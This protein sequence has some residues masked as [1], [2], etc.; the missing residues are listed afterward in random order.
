MAGRLI[1]ARRVDAIV[2]DQRFAPSAIAARARRKWWTA[3]AACPPYALQSHFLHTWAKPRSVMLHAGAP[4]Q[5]PRIVSND[6]RSP[7]AVSARIALPGKRPPLGTILDYDNSTPPLG[8]HSGAPMKAGYGRRCISKMG[9]RHETHHGHHQAFQ[10]R[11][12]AGGADAAGRAGSH[13]HRG[14]GFRPPKGP[15]RDLPRRR[16]PRELSA[17]GEDRGRGAPTTWSTRSSRRSPRPPTPARSATAR[18]SS[19]TSSVRCASAP[20]RPTARRI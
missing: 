5:L 10:A 18:S 16:V 3:Q 17:Q 13:R 7:W 8:L 6:R 4:R 2:A 14:E 11:R 15:D 1:P 19:S 9:Q 20:A 12:R